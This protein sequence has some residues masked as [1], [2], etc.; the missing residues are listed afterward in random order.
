MEH[1]SMN[2]EYERVVTQI[3]IKPKG[4]PIFHELATTIRI[5]DEAAGP[6]VVVSQCSSLASKQEITVD[7]D[8]WDSLKNGIDEMIRECIAL[9]LTAKS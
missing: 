4:E 8:S 2:T 9:E 5:E 7:I 3:T 1:E 6:Y